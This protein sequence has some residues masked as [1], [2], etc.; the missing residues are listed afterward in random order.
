MNKIQMTATRVGVIQMICDIYPRDSCK[1]PDKTNTCD[2]IEQK[3][4]YE[5]TVWLY[6]CNT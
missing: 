6:A 3:Y 4:T 1:F 2:N 5:E